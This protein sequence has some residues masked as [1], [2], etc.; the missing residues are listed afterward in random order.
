MW[1]FEQFRLC[2]FDSIERLLKG[3]SESKNNCWPRSFWP[4]LTWIKIGNILTTTFSCLKINWA[5]LI[6]K[7]LIFHD[8]ATAW[9]ITE[10]FLPQLF[11][12]DITDLDWRSYIKSYCIGLK[13]H[14]FKE[15]L[16][17]APIYRQRNLKWECHDLNWWKNIFQIFKNL[18]EKTHQTIGVRRH[19]RV[20]HQVLS[21]A[22]ETFWKCGAFRL[23]AGAHVW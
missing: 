3:L 1:V 17:R 7:Y 5:K 19:G 22:F 12:F 9:F 15:E 14:I 10:F 18:Q 2:L 23:F 21:H 6:I 16:S 20:Y 11:N 4:R 8:E 13:I